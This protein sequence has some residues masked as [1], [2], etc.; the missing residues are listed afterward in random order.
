ML[1]MPQHRP[2]LLTSC[3]VVLIQSRQLQPAA[4]PPSHSSC[5]LTKVA[6]CPTFPTRGLNL[7]PVR[8]AGTTRPE[9]LPM[10]HHSSSPLLLQMPCRDA[11]SILQQHP[12][13]SPPPPGVCCGEKLR[14][15][16]KSKVG[17]CQV[18]G[19]PLLP[20]GPLGAVAGGQAAACCV[21]SG[22]KHDASDALAGEGLAVE[23]GGNSFK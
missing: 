3:D 16:V 2:Q 21:L 6:T 20:E 13:P 17:P 7:C 12:A 1:S 8:G 23:C 19:Q 11:E 10:V 22:V 14:S 15:M 18:S 9:T 5:W 4:C